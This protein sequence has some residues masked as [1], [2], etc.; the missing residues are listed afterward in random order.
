MRKLLRLG[1]ARG[2]IAELA[3]GGVAFAERRS[4]REQ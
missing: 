4:E 3:R 2:G 1:E